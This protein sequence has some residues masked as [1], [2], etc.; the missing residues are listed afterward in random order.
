MERGSLDEL[1]QFDRA[2]REVGL[3]EHAFREPPEEPRHPGLDDVASRT[4]HWR[5]RRY[6]LNK[7]N[8]VVLVTAGS[9]KCEHQGTAV[10]GASLEAMDEQ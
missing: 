5:A 8:Q 4:Q 9:V 3:V 7:R 10:N 6:R 2:A 1:R